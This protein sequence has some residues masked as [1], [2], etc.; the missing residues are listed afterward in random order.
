MFHDFPEELRLTAVMAATEDAP[1]THKANNQSIELQCERS[2]E[3]E[4]LKKELGLEDEQ[5]N[6]IEALIIHRMWYSHKC[7]KTAT[8]VTKSFKAL[9]F[10]KENL[11]MLKDN[12]K[13]P[14]I[15]FGW[16]KFKTKWSKD[17]R[18]KSIPE[19]ERRLKDI[20][21]KTK[22]KK[23]PPRPEVTIPERTNME[24]LGQ[25]THQLSTLDE[26]A[27]YTSSDFDKG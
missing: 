26:K 7:C 12:I 13:I 5:E 27:A 10:K 16:E 11:D 4:D 6:Y 3:K 2:Q 9:T 8:E 15:A 22:G 19:L 14:V 17:G 25:I 23:I 21:E 20:I 18:Q 24:I 1:V